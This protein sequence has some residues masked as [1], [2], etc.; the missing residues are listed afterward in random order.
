MVSSS[1][2]A[3]YVGV[4]LFVITLIAVSYTP[5][6]NQSTASAAVES[7]PGSDTS[8]SS[9]SSQVSVDKLVA[10]SI[11]SSLAESTYVPVV[12]N[13]ANLAKTLE[14]ENYL[15]QS[16]VDVVS[17]PKII[18][19]MAD[20]Q[21]VLEYV[22]VDGDTVQSVATKYSIS[23]QTVKW[24]NNLTADNLKVGTTLKIPP[25]DGIIYTVKDGDTTQSIADTYKASAAEIIAYNDLELQDKPATGT[26]LFVPNGTLPEQDRP[27]Y[28]APYVAP[29]RSYA[30]RIGF[31]YGFAGG[32]L[33][34]VDPSSYL[35]A[36]VSIYGSHTRAGSDGQCTWYVYFRR[37]AMGI[38][39]P[40]QALGNA[41]YWADTLRPFFGVDRNPSV[42]AIIQE[43][44]G[45]SG[46]V[47]VVEK[48]NADGSIEITEMNNYAAGGSF[49]VDRRTIPAYAVDS[50]NYIH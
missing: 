2:I 24:A 41:K 33:V 15:A 29:M 32:G 18:Q 43:S 10:T 25:V 40:D 42:G 31:A 47:G 6:V 28:V 39:I 34:V 3:S 45:W 16:N 12:N 4:F 27:G 44:S 22:V 23:T 37:M 17:K 13:V 30:G 7:L 36:G 50:F 46:H 26:V 5:P 19:P 11:A 14:V 20:N 48:V 38:P 35:P 49:V 8:T 9:D 1:A 21:K